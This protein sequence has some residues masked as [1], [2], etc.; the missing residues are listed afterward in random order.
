MAKSP[1]KADMKVDSVKEKLS[2][3]KEM[4][5]FKP[6]KIEVKGLKSKAKTAKKPKTGYKMLGKAM[7]R[8][9]ASKK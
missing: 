9:S 4:F 6:K 7:K 8:L 3:P 1:K 5:S 2:E